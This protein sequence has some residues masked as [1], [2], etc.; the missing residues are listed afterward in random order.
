MIPIVQLFSDF[1]IS[2]ILNWGYL[3]IIVLMAMESSN[4]PIP[5]EIVMPFAGYLVYLGKLDFITVVLAGTLGNLIG[6]ILSYWGG[7]YIGRTAILKYG[8]YVLISEK[9]L[10]WADSWFAKYGHKAVFISR[11]LPVIRTFISTPAG[12]TKMDFKK[13]V[14]YTTLGS[15]PWNFALAYLGI[16]LGPN[17]NSMINFFHMFDIVIIFAIIV[18]AVWYWKKIKSN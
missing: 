9:K 3:S 1:L 7:M 10:N 15:L 17:W 14:L 11:M 2:L 13:F 12:I 6:S 4:L 18:F 8:K 16:Y 5:R